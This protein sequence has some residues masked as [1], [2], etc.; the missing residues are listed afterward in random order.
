MKIYKCPEC[1]YETDDS[2]DS[3][4]TCPDCQVEMDEEDE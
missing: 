1:G 2:L 4:F 3:E